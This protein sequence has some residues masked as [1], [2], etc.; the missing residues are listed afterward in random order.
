MDHKLCDF[1]VGSGSTSW[2]SHDVTTQRINRRE[3][4]R[5]QHDPGGSAT[6]RALTARP[7]TTS[8]A[9][10][11]GFWD[12]KHMA[13]GSHE[14]R[15]RHSDLVASAVR[16]PARQSFECTQLALSLI[17]LE[18]CLQWLSFEQTCLSTGTIF[19]VII[20]HKW[21]NYHIAA[22]SYH[23]CRLSYPQK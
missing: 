19:C 14:A 21:C 16:R 17:Q 18:R 22:K 10:T 2:G 6:Q 23:H 1:E 8:L 12:L 13:R 11:V 20:Y 9:M 7:L 3:G 4:G 15:G 5:Q